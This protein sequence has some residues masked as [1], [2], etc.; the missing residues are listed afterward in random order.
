MKLG[1]AITSHGTKLDRSFFLFLICE[2]FVDAHKMLTA[3]YIVS[4]PPI[5]KKIIKLMDKTM[6]QRVRRGLL[7]ALAALAG[8]SLAAAPGGSACINSCYCHSSGSTAPQNPGTLFGA[9]GGRDKQGNKDNPA[10]RVFGSRKPEYQPICG[11][12]E[13]KNMCTL[14]SAEYYSTTLTCPVLQ[15]YD[16]LEKVKTQWITGKHKIYVNNSLATSD[17]CVGERKILKLRVQ[18]V[19]RGR[20]PDDAIIYYNQTESMI[21]KEF[22]EIDLN[23]NNAE[24]DWC[25]ENDAPALAPAPASV[26]T[27][28]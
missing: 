22:A 13:V 27:R 28:H 21:F 25:C 8:S 24:R 18:I 17:P 2:R 12:T 1:I 4:D 3:A 16:V 14:I 23:T 9:T 10:A 20:D 5:V 6:P 11:H 19:S 15:N 26:F 7:A